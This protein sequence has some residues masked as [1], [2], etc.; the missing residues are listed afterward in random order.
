MFAVVFKDD[1]FNYYQVG[2]K[3]LP[4]EPI[5]TMGA[6][7]ALSTKEVSEDRREETE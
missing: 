2:L 1:D 6:S 5:K 3:A 4:P 7:R